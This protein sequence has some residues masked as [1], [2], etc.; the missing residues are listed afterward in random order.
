MLG[1]YYASSDSSVST[2]DEALPPRAGCA[3]NRGPGPVHTHT[4]TRSALS[5][6]DRDRFRHA[7]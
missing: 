1:R 5:D 4:N 6:P 2:L 3:A 7:K